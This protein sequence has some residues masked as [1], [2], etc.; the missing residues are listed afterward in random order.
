MH[1]SLVMYDVYKD[2]CCIQLMK[3]FSHGVAHA[4]MAAMYVYV[5]SLRA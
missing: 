5:Q 3:Y 4:C 1:I 2:V